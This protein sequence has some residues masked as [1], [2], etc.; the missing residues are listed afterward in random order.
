[1]APLLSARCGQENQ[2][3]PTQVSRVVRL[4]ILAEGPFEKVF[5]S[6]K[7]SVLTTGEQAVKM[8][9]EDGEIAIRVVDAGVVVIRHSDGKCDLDLRVHGGQSEA[10]DEGVVGVVVGAQ[11]EATL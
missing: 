3:T 9:G 2:S 7:V 8:L 11:E 6:A 4:I 5:E 1:M 10:I